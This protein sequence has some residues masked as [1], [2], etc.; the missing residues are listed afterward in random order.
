MCYDLEYHLNFKVHNNI[1]DVASSTVIYHCIDT[2][3]FLP[4]NNTDFP[5]NQLTDS[6]NFT[7]MNAIY[8]IT[9]N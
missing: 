3:H 5:Y 8:D 6:N 2:N 9:V 4:V 1:H 7:Q